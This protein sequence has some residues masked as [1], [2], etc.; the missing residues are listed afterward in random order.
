MYAHMYFS[1]NCNY[2]IH[3]R[4]HGRPQFVIRVRP[5]RRVIYAAFLV[6]ATV[7]TQ[8]VSEYAH[9]DHCHICTCM[10]AL[11]H[12]TRI[13]FHVQVHCS[14]T[15]RIIKLGQSQWNAFSNKEK[16]LCVRWRAKIPNLKLK[17][18]HMYMLNYILYI[19][20]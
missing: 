2:V 14:A 12:A 16:Y 17:V 6:M 18:M 13:S 11:S 8:S 7:A 1:Q 19:R 9:N 15:H 3:T 5:T 4:L 20:A 10:Y